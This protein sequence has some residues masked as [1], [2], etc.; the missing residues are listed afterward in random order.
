MTTV[1]ML[2]AK[3]SPSKL[4][5]AVESGVENEIIIARNGKPGAVNS[6]D[7][8]E[9][10]KKRQWGCLPANIRQMDFE[11]FQA[12]DAEI[13]A[14]FLGEGREE[15]GGFSSIPY[16]HLDTD[17]AATY[18][19]KYHGTSRD[20]VNTVAVSAIVVLEMAI[21]HQLGCVTA[22]HFGSRGNR[23]FRALLVSVTLGG[24][25]GVCRAPSSQPPP[26]R[27]VDVGAGDYGKHAVRERDRL[28]IALRR[29]VTWS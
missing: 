9:P 29:L 4:V 25:C 17:R 11:A 5:E 24:S 23:A 8:H 2:E 1:N 10:R 3:T 12:M 18:P 15:K 27:P 13:E 6:C 16:R 19:G 20:P 14:M 7:L 21:K 22:R 28:L 26:V